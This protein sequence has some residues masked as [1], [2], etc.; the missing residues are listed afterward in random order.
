MMDCDTTGI[1]PDLGL[2]KFKNLVGGGQMKFV[3]QTARRGLVSLGYNSAEINGIINYIEENHSIVGAPH[4]NDDHL[5]VFACSIGDNTIDVLGH[6]K[7]MESVQPFL[8]G[9]ISKTVNMPEESTIEDVEHIYAEAWRRG[10]KAIAIYRDNCKVA[11]PVSVSSDAKDSETG[12]DAKD[13]QE[14]NPQETAGFVFKGTVKR[15]LS[16]IRNSKTFKFRLADNKGY[17]TV[18]E[19]EDGTPAEIFIVVSKQGSTLAGVMDAL[20]I[21]V[22]HGLQYGVPLKSYV[23]SFINMS[24]APSGLTDDSE[25]RTATSFVDY[26]FRRIAKAYLSYED[27]VDL[28]IITF[29]DQLAKEAEMQTKLL[30]D[31]SAASAD[32]AT[33]PAP[34]TME[35]PTLIVPNPTSDLSSPMCLACGNP[36]QRAGACYVCRTCG[37]STGCS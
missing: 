1:E 31:E 22:S 28:G 29:S 4:F 8:S 16:S 2:V 13:L 23:K 14:F 19:F 20:A 27:L 36:T 11:Q 25:V 26:I 35:T 5:D 12:K 24:F 10:L 15:P 6:V 7:M 18:G 32:A 34:T 21:S 33:A 30:D 17:M 37:L 3:N 9:A